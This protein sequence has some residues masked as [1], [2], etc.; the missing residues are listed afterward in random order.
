MGDDSHDSLVRHF[1]P[2]WYAAVMGTGGLANVLYL[3]GA[4][5]GILRPVGIA[6]WVLNILLFALLI[7]PWT[8]RWFFHFDRLVEDLRHPMMSN[9]FVTMPVGALILGTNF[10]LMGR[11]LLPP[12]LVATLGLVLWAFGTVTILLFGVMVIYNM[13][14]R[15]SM[16]PEMVNFSWF[17]TPVA[18]IVVP[19]LGNPLVATYAARN[20]E[21]AGFI[22]VIDISFY[23]IGLMLFLVIG[24]ILFNRLIHHEMPHP[25]VAPTF[26]IILGPI[27]VGTVSLMGIADA[28]KL[29][30]LIE[31]AH[32]IYLAALVLWGFGLWA[33][34]LTVAISTR[35][36]RETG[37]PF[38][39]SWWAFIFPLAAYVMSAYSVS[40]YLHSRPL[41]WYAVLLGVI[42]TVLWVVVFVRSALAVLR[43]ELIRPNTQPKRA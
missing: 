40:V 29:L 19:L 1:S 34:A 13:I 7:G 21:L 36:L 42:L 28:S 31:S 41:F 4:Q 26:W 32:G 24:S 39:I 3:F 14:V 43:G 22:N 37:I 12:A 18:S 2:A 25:L 15:E 5:V 30:G 35:Y 9:F 20:A 27:G 6:L 16:A 17:I 33:L 10:V 38:S 11:G 23:G 8:A